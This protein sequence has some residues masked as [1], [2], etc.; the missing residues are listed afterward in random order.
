[1]FEKEYDDYL[2]EISNYSE[3]KKDEIIDWREVKGKEK[4]KKKRLIYI[5]S[6]RSNSIDCLPYLYLLKQA[7][8]F[9]II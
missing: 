8:K 5:A 7:H 6:T 1:M 9:T 4:E 3:N 2:K